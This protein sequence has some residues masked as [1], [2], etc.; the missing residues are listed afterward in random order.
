VTAL[1]VPS[2]EALE[3]YAKK[4]NIAFSSRGE[5]IKKPE[6]IKFYADR[7]EQRTHE[8]G[9]VEKVKKFTLLPAEFTQENGEITP[10][11]KIKR[12]PIL[13]RYADIIEAMYR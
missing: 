7:I 13:E 3:T 11:M 5:L 10:T 4:N 2:F 1:I 6:I 8:L 9:Q 12:K